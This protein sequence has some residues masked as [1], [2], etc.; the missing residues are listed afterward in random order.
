INEYIMVYRKKTPRN[1]EWNINK[2]DAQIIKDSKVKGDYESSNIWQIEP[3]YDKHHSAIFP[4]ELCKRIITYYSFINDVVLDPFAGSGTLGSV[5]HELKRNSILIEKNK[6]Y[7]QIL[8]D[9]FS[10]IDK[11]SF[12][13]TNSLKKKLDNG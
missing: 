7:F 11:F 8:K 4:K 5:A 1:V 10:T 12:L 6:K 9:K 2:Y 3:C 13:D